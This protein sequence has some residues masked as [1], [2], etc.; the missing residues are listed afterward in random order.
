MTSKRKPTLQKLWG[1]VN[2]LH[3]PRQGLQAMLDEAG[4]AIKALYVMGANPASEDAAWAKNL[5]KLDLL[6]VQELF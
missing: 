2:F 4:G 3:H 1:K 6:V 5:D